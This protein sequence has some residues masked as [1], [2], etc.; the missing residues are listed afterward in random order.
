MC[1]KLTFGMS[2][3]P[4]KW[5][6][7]SVLRRK[8]LSLFLYKEF[9][10]PFPPL[11]PCP[12]VKETHFSRW[13]QVLPV[14]SSTNPSDSICQPLSCLENHCTCLVFEYLVLMNVLN[15]QCFVRSLLR[16]RDSYNFW[17]CSSV[18][19]Q[20]G[21]TSSLS[22]LLSKCVHMCVRAFVCVC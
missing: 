10:M 19:V 1:A 4:S 6:A 7:K 14:S 8:C 5:H 13:T 11:P 15:I 22:W 20:Q 12:L 16:M 2:W 17:G 3:V 21:R 18:K 9:K